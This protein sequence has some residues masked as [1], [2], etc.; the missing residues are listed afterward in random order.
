M[1]L[2]GRGGGSGDWSQAV[3][4]VP[5]LSDYGLVLSSIFFSPAFRVCFFSFE[6][7]M[8]APPAILL[9]SRLPRGYLWIVSPSRPFVPWSSSKLVWAGRVCLSNAS[10]SL[11]SLAFIHFVV[12]HGPYIVCQIA[13]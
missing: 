13:V 12:S 7:A 8:K 2:I 1:L 11:A 4:V 10:V 9:L 5:L 3:H 6:K